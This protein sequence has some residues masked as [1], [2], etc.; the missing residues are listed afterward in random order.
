MSQCRWERKSREGLECLRVSHTTFCEETEA[1]V[2][3]P[4][5]P[6]KQDVVVRSDVKALWPGRGFVLHEMC[7]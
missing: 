4:A 7:S 2:L 6:H 1:G 3:C 5:A